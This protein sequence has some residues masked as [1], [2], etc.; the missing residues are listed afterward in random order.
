[1]AVQYAFVNTHGEVLQ[2]LSPGADTDYT[3]GEMYSGMMAVAVSS[4]T[5]GEDLMNN[6]YYHNNEWLDKPTRPSSGH[7]YVFENQQWVAGG[8]DLL[9]E[10]RFKRN[11]LI[12]ESD[13]TQLSDSPLSSQL[14][15]DWAT[16]RQSLR[17]ITD[18]LTG[19]STP[20]DVVWPTKP[21]G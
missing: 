18:D 9:Q 5:I 16:Y 19:I 2:V 15:Q 12:G 17:D 20:D 10:I 13:W 4:E 21:G 7:W 3:E 14:K 1:M 8:F 6:K 11:Q